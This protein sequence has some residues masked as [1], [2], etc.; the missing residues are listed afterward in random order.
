MFSFIVKEP[1]SYLLLFADPGA[2]GGID[3]DSDLIT[4]VAKDCP[5]TA[6][7]KL[8]HVSALRHYAQNV[9]SVLTT[10]SRPDAATSAN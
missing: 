7:V 3:L 4:E 8:T 6:G 2:S 9:L 10:F 1:T 5:N